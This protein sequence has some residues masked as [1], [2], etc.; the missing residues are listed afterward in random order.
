MIRN[1][2]N[3][4]TYPKNINLVLLILRVAAGVLMLTHGIG[5]IA[6]LFGSEPIRFPDPIGLGAPITLALTVFAEV[7]C[8]IFL[9]LGLGTRLAAIPLFITMLVAAL[10]FHANDPFGKQ[11]LPLIY[12]SIYLVI[13]I[14]GAGL[15]SMDNWIFKSLNRQRI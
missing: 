7:L 6:P 9:I 5:K 3:P 15:I 13:A 1:I 8:S 2:F 12:T 11:E 10:V 4:G 14:A